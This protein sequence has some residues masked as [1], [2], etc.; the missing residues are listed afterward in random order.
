MKILTAGFVLGLA[1]LAGAERPVVTLRGEAAHLSIDL[2]GGGIVDFH[3]TPDGVNPLKWEGEGG[4]LEP[5]NRAHFLCLDRVGR[6]S[7]AE[8]ARG[9]PFHGEAGRGMWTL[10]REPETVGATV[11]AEMA[12]ELPLAGMR[13]ERFVRLQGKHFAV[14]EEVTNQNA[15][16]RI[17]NMVQHPTIGPPFLE[18]GSLVDANA[19]KGFMLS[20]PMPNPEE[21]AVYW[22]QALDEGM[23]VNLRRLVD[24]HDPQ[25][26][27]YVIDDEYG[28][29]TATTPKYGLL[30]GYIWKNAE[31]PWF[32]AWRHVRDGRPFARGLEFGTTGP[33]T[34]FGFLVDKGRIFGR[35]L[36][37]YIDAGETIG[38]SYLCFLA[39]V[40]TDFAG[41]GNLDYDGRQAVLTEWRGER[42]V[43]VDLGTWP[44]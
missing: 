39:E 44:E 22:P 37:D 20:N 21:P 5:R 17:Y 3:L 25:V 35:A 2:A 4:E 43:T 24:D 6:P 7:Q 36:F 15:L 28:W 13:V 11:V 18:E 30:I 16:G 12:A 14:R 29:T 19:R 42:Q 40:P 8:L 32:R 38:R 27:V 41:V 33:G 31:Y 34:P 10:V 26:V 9:M 1:V 23:P